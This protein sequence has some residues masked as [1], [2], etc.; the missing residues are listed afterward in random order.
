MRILHATISTAGWSTN[1]HN[2]DVFQAS[3]HLS[4]S[5]FIPHLF[6]NQLLWPEE[7][8]PLTGHTESDFPPLSCGWSQCHLQHP[9]E[10][11]KGSLLKEEQKDAQST[12][13][14]SWRCESPSH[15][16]SINNGHGQKKADAGLFFPLSI[17]KAFSHLLYHFPKKWS[18]IFFFLNENLFLAYSVYLPTEQLG[19]YL[20][21]TSHSFP[22]EVIPVTSFQVF[23]VRHKRKEKSFPEK[24]K[25][26][27]QNQLLIHFQ[28]KESSHL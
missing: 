22:K 9:R 18:W 23:W 28:G 11:T 17:I 10:E 5:G 13:L 6:L 27:R 19:H 24:S 14:N 8:K 12:Q 3:S 2:K 25:S 7:H 21:R 16:A 26:N 4:G 20:W 1:F 15:T